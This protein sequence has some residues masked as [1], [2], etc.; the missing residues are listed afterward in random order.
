VQCG[1][2]VA[3]GRINNDASENT[4]DLTVKQH[5]QHHFWQVG[6]VSATT[7]RLLYRAGVQLLHDLHYKSSQAVF[8]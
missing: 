8:V 7:I 1:F 5:S 4:F 3:N 2:A 6:R